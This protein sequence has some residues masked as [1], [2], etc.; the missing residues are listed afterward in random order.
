[1]KKRVS[2]LLLFLVALG[3]TSCSDRNSL[4][5]YFVDNAEK[6]GFSSS[7]IPMS[8]L[9]Q[10]GISFSKKQEEAMEAIQRVNLLFYKTNPQKQDEFATEKNTV[11]TILKQEKYEELINLGDRGVVKYIGSDDAMNEIVIFVSDKQMGFA[12]ARISG[13]DITMEKL[14]ELYKLTQQ[15]E[16]L[17]NLNLGS[18]TNFMSA[19]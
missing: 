14:M 15:K 13:E 12:V 11:K 18:L 4:H 5:N 16:V 9:K 8:L 19:N 3:I 6:S 17:S 7:T 1:M 2:L 10:E